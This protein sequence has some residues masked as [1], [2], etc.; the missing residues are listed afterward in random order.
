[1]I[2]CARY[3]EISLWIISLLVIFDMKGDKKD[4]KKETI[5]QHLEITSSLFTLLIGMK[6]RNYQLFLTY[7][8]LF[9]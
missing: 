6:I 2:L 9:A 3:Y 8:F 5:V 1:M 4:D 7:S